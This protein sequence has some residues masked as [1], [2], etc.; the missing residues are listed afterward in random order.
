VAKIL[1]VDD[2]EELREDVVEM[3]QREGY[4]VIDVGTGEEAIEKLKKES[5][6]IILTDLMM[7]G[8]DGMEVLRQSKKLKPAVRVIMITGFGTIENA[9]EAMKEGASDYISKPFKIGEVQATVKR[10]LEEVKFAKSLSA[11]GMEDKRMQDIMSSLS[12]PIRRAAIDYLF[13]KGRKSFMN[14]FEELGV[15][16]H[17]KLSF[18]LRKLKS[19]GM[20]EQNEK[21]KYA[22]SPEGKKIAE[23]LKNLKGFAL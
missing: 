13:L 11:S 9:V 14:I 4:E 12:N 1:V 21:K 23:T 7:P 17:T 20:L 2:D 16:D 5:V 19:S 15:E 6:D 8:I 10:A 18:H 22:L 3:L